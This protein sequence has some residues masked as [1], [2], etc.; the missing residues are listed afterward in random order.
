MKEAKA[1]IDALKGIAKMMSKLE[2]DRVKGYKKAPVE[3][4]IE[5]EESEDDDEGLMKVLDAKAFKK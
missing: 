3:P 1:K 5:D 2:L 4:E